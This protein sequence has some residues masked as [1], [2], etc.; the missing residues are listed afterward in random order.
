MATFPNASSDVACFDRVA[1]SCPGLGRVD[2]MQADLDLGLFRLDHGERVA[3]GNA[4]H[5]GGEVDGATGR[6]GQEIRRSVGA[7]RRMT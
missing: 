1:K 7:R 6:R 4:D 5:L 3:V 2:A